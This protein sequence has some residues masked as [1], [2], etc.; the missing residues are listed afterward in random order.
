M[1]NQEGV[2]SIVGCMR[3][4][5][6]LVSQL[7]GKTFVY[8]GK[9]EELIGGGLKD[10]NGIWENR[11]FQNV[12][13]DI[14][15]YNGGNFVHLKMI[16]DFVAINWDDPDII[17][18]NEPLY[19]LAWEVLDHLSISNMK[20]EFPKTWVGWKDPR[21]SLTLNYWRRSIIEGSHKGR[22]ESKHRIKKVL[23]CVRHPQ[24]AARSMASLGYGKVNNYHY[25]F[26]LWHLY[27]QSIMDTLSTGNFPFLVVKHRELFTNTDN[28]IDR[29]VNFF[30]LDEK[31]DIVGYRNTM[32]SIIDPSLYRFQNEEYDRPSELFNEIMNL[33]EAQ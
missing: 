9:D 7:L 26:H 15:K 23:W 5:T 27:N 4:G 19:S 6:S 29:I 16:R 10:P 24:E 11:L 1:N 25:F 2:V 31:E 33:K 22:L 8:F 14:L 17:E 21:N 13:K 28:E 32:K 12:N 18:Q 20:Q 30:D 3:N